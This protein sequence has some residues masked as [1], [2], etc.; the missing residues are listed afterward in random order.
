MWMSIAMFSYAQ[1]N[2]D[3]A[4]AYYNRAEKSYASNDYNAAIDDLDKAIGLLEGKS[5]TKIEYLFTQCY[6]HKKDFQNAQILLRRFFNLNPKTSTSMYAELINLTLEINDEVD[7]QRKEEIAEQKRLYEQQLKEQEY[8]NMLRN[9]AATLKED[10]SYKI[11]EFLF[12]EEGKPYAVV[13]RENLS[14]SDDERSILIFYGDKYIIY[15]VPSKKLVEGLFK[16]KVV[17]SSYNASAGSTTIKMKLKRNGIKREV[18][19]KKGIHYSNIF[20]GGFGDELMWTK[21]TQYNQFDEDLYYYYYYHTLHCDVEMNKK[22]SENYYNP[23]IETG[24]VIKTVDYNIIKDKDLYAT[25][26]KAGVVHKESSDYNNPE[27]LSITLKPNSNIKMLFTKKSITYQMVDKVKGKYT[28]EGTV[29]KGDFLYYRPK[30]I[31]THYAFIQYDLSYQEFS[32]MSSVRR[33]KNSVNFTEEFFNSVYNS[34][35]KNTTVGEIRYFTSSDYSGFFEIIPFIYGGNLSNA[36]SVFVVE[37]MWDDAVKLNNLA[38]KFY[39][40]QYGKEE[41]LDAITWVERS[42]ELQENSSNLDTYAALLYK[43]NN[44]QK[45]YEMAEK[46]ISLAKESGSDYSQTEEL[47]EKIKIEL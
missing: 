41:L 12:Y 21:G 7:R 34:F 39:N 40:N 6:Y 30:D 9:I 33:I 15:T 23:Y 8:E 46:S 5:F 43:T 1:S 16:D 29:Y 17:F 45:A 11:N 19:F 47:L 2:G 27:T 20:L 18:T 13:T 14:T 24:E 35:K 38:W 44:Y 37:D 31:S 42:I 3:L 32:L 26:K 28:K 10:I 25:L 22:I 4:K 36:L